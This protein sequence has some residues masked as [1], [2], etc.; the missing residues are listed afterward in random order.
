MTQTKPAIAS[1]AV[2]GSIIVGISAAGKIAGIN[3]PLVDEPGLAL[4]IATMFGAALALH[5]RV[6]ANTVIRGWFK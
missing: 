2:W 4:D 6:K 5:G 3:I 1:E